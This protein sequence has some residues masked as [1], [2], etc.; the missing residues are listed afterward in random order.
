MGGK[1]LTRIVFIVACLFTFVAN[2]QVTSFTSI[3]AAT[4]SGNNHTL[5]ICAGSQ[6]LFIS[7]TH[8]IQDNTSGGIYALQNPTNYSWNFGT[9]ASPAQMNIQG[10]H[11][12]TYNTP[13]TYTVTLTAQSNGLNYTQPFTFTINVSAGPSLSFT[14]GLVSGTSVTNVGC[15]VSSTYNMY[16]NQPYGFTAPVFQTV[17]TNNTCTCAEGPTLAIPNAT[18]Y[19]AG[20]TASI[21][22]GG[23][24]QGGL[25]TGSITLGPSA[26][27]S[28]LVSFPGQSN[29]SGFVTHYTSTGSYNL[30]YM[31]NI[32]GCT[33]SKYY[34]VNYGA[35]IISYNTVGQNVCLPE[36]L[37]L[38]FT[39]QSPGNTYTINWGD[40]TTQTI[41]YPSLN[42]S[43]NTVPHQYL[44]SCTQTGPAQPYQIQITATNQCPVVS[45][46]IPTTTSPA[47]FYVS[48][49]PTAAFTSNP[50][51]P[52]ICD[53][54]SITFTNSTI[55]GLYQINGTCDDDYS[56]AW[57][58]LNSNNQASGFSLTNGT[59]G[60]YNSGGSPSITA[61]FNTPGTYTVSLT[62][63]NV[64]CGNNTF[65]Q[66]ITV[67]PYPIIPNQTANAICTGGTFVVSPTNSPPTS[68][69]PSG[70]TYSW[71]P[72]SNP[73]IGG[74]VSSSGSNITG[75]LTNTT[76]SLQTQVYTVT[77]QAGVCVGPTFTVS[78]PVFPNVSVNDAAITVCNGTPFT[79]A[80]TN[81]GGNSLPS[82][83]TY[84]WT[85]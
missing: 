64:V 18:S 35:G 84:T 30:V 69:V 85:F 70:T 38:E 41:G 5:N 10:P 83:T 48:A 7:N 80:P 62:A 54:Q 82:G 55:A 36:G 17:G 71:V 19:P 43:P 29:S 23:N 31:V 8:T 53:D 11:V 9:G 50:S 52:T 65:T 75:S 68:I 39:N 76:S 81:G 51:P 25:T 24:G 1:L 46:G 32:G 4:I 59:L 34:I 15:T 49:A 40:G 6:V 27:A 22:W 60:T 44:T 20:T 74:A 61:L 66:T 21:Y 67:N 63:S 16:P 3:P 14:P 77:P 12:V 73:N 58:I 45:G 42:T 26:A 78:V 79:Y 47:Q 28:T 37:N 2:G 72:I 57:S 33:L 13:G 56:F